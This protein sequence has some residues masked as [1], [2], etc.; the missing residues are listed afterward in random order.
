MVLVIGVLSHNIGMIV[1]FVLTC[2]I[3]LDEEIFIG[4]VFAELRGHVMRDGVFILAGKQ[5]NRC[6]AEDG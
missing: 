6:H 1:V 3:G 4:A 5:H 2:R